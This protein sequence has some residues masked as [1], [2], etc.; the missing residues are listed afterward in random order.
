VR[1]IDAEPRNSAVVPAGRVEG[2]AGTSPRVYSRAMRVFRRAAIVVLSAGCG[3]STSYD[4]PV[5]A[6]SDDGACGVPAGYVGLD[7]TVPDGGPCRAAT[8]CPLDSSPN[9]VIPPVEAGV[10]AT[11]GEDSAQSP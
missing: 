11:F 8:W 7:E 1:D 2:S 9:C 3:C 6:W 5:L 4:G 10:D